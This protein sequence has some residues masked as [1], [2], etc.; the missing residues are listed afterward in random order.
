MSDKKTWVFLD[1][2]KLPG[3]NYKEGAAKK[4]LPTISAKMV[5]G[6]EQV[7][8][9]F[10]NNVL[11]QFIEYAMCEYNSIK[12]AIDMDLKPEEVIANFDNKD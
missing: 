4:N 2:I 10:P 12:E 3:I 11:D 1:G 6:K 9:T 8:I 7:N 5:D